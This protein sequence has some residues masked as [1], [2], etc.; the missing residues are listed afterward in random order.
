MIRCG[1]AYGW[2]ATRRR[3]RSLILPML[4]VATGSFLLVWVLILT[5]TVRAQASQLGDQAEVVRATVLIAV[6]VLLVGV[7]EVAVCTTRT[8]VARSRELGVLGAT[9]VGRQSVVAALLVEPVMAA[10]IGSALGGAVA[11]A[12]AYLLAAAGALDASPV[13][14]TAVLAGALSFGVSAVTALLTSV[15]PSWRAASRPPV[16]SLNSGG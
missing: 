5:Q 7:V 10:A 4:T 3:M 16:R 14:S 1:L 13:A 2:L 8:I 9:G 6:V 11:I 12:A 15:V